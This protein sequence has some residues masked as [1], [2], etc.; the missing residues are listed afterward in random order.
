MQTVIVRFGVMIAPS[1]LV[2]CPGARAQGLTTGIRR[3][4]DKQAAVIFT[5]LAQQP[6]LAATVPPVG[7]REEKPQPIPRSTSQFPQETPAAALPFSGLLPE[8]LS[9]ADSPPPVQSLLPLFATARSSLPNGKLNI[10]KGAMT[11]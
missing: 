4:A 5:E 1:M 3:V 10:R 2:F 9:T 11:P 6:A 8:V 7:V